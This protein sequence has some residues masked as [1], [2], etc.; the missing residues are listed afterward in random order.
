MLDGDLLRSVQREAVRL[1]VLCDPLPE[2]RTVA[3][4]SEVAIAIVRRFSHSPVHP[5]TRS[6]VY[7][8]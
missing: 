3:R 8:F 6:R 1:R 5:F 2:I 7:G 4:Q